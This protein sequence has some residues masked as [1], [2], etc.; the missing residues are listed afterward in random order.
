MKE[1]VKILKPFE[2]ATTYLGGSS[3]VT[4]SIMYPLIQ[5]IKT[6][7]KNNIQLNFI[8]NFESFNLEELGDVFNDE[9]IEEIED[10]EQNDLNLNQPMQTE[11][12]LGIVNRI[13]YNSMNFYWNFENKEYMIAVM[14]DPHTKQLNFIKGKIHTFKF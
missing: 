3:Y 7:L 9:F 5:E 12:V 13:L 11:G 1:L 2:E 8:S 10:A 14:L 4:F 6:R